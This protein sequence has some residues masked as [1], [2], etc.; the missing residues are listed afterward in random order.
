MT[1]QHS[2]YGYRCEECRL[3]VSRPAAHKKCDGKLQLINRNTMTFTKE[4]EEQYRNFQRERD[5]KIIIEKVSPLEKVEKQKNNRRNSHLKVKKSKV[6]PKK[7]SILENLY[8]PLSMKFSDDQQNRDLKT[9]KEKNKKKDKMGKENKDVNRGRKETETY[10]K[11]QATGTDNVT[12]TEKKERNE[13]KEEGTSS[14]RKNKL[15]VLM[16]ELN[17]SA[18]SE[19]MISLCDEKDGQFSDAEEEVEMK[20]SP[21]TACNA[22]K[23]LDMEIVTE[24][25]NNPDSSQVS[26]II[27]SPVSSTPNISILPLEPLVS[28]ITLITPISEK[29]KQPTATDLYVPAAT[30]V[31]TELSY[32][33]TPTKTLKLE[34]IQ[35]SQQTRFILNVGG[36]KFET[37]A[38]VINNYPNSVL[39][40][41][42]APGSVVTPYS[43]DGR[44]CYFLDRDPKH[45]PIIINYLRNKARLHSDILPRDL[46]QLRELQI[47]CNFYEL[48]H[49]ESHVQKKIVDIQHCGLI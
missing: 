21:V 46:K 5:R 26:A 4:E 6:S 17:T 30:T 3:V 2:G 13:R 49:L 40:A 35:K 34:A 36:M 8:K 15:E 7:R 9:K 23:N 48:S 31:D 14:D 25:E 33:P 37:S 12:G 42:I 28:P 44:A 19:E 38:S 22:D 47:E 43:I 41:M 20:D 18:D 16:E 45:F 11:S 24:E 10:K 32:I 29:E 39:S 27:N 1:E